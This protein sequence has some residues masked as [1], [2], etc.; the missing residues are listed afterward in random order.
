MQ[1]HTLIEYELVQI[2]NDI[3]IMNPSSSMDIEKHPKRCE[4]CATLKKISK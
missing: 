4:W 2:L 3:I 1:K